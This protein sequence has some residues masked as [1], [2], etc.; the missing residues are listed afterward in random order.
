MK[1][2]SCRYFLLAVLASFLSWAFVS[3]YAQAHVL[4]VKPETRERKI[5]PYDVNVL[6]GGPG[7]T[8]AVPPGSEVLTATGAS[9]L[10]TWVFFDQRVPQ[11]TLIAGLGDPSHQDSRFLGLREHRPLLRF[12]KGHEI[13]GHSPLTTPGWHLLSA[14][15]GPQGVHL[16]ADGVEVAESPQI[17][18]RVD[19]ELMIAPTEDLSAEGFHHFGGIAAQVIVEPEEVAGET[20]RKM[21][22]LPPDIALLRLE[23]AS[24]PWPVQVREQ[25]GYL[26]PQDPAL[27]PRSRA[28]FGKPVALPLQAL[29]T[30]ALTP[31]DD[32]TWVVNHNWM[33]AAA[34][35][36]PSDGPALSQG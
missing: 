22:S 1:S 12:G 16:Y 2:V 36:E 3:A 4:T 32:H 18:G 25:V 13:A 10:S 21:A 11:T 31:L 24:Q 35:D 30:T 27:M 33:L 19:A 20:I 26:A 7:L 14:T 6:Q 29:S 8:K 5:G 34:P 28:K 17:R 23:E 15:F 9:T